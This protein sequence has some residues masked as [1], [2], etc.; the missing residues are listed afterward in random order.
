[1]GTTDAGSSNPTPHSAAHLF[2]NATLCLTLSYRSSI[3]FPL[4]PNQ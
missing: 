3:E 2:R 1:L 4:C